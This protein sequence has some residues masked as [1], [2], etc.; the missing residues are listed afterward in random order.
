MHWR[1]WDWLTTPKSLGGMGF[2]DMALFN[3]AMLGR[4]G[5]RILSSPDS[6]CARV[7]KGRYFPQGDFWHAEVPRSASYTWRHI[8]FGR[9]LFQRGIQWGIGDG[10]KVRITGDHWIPSTPPNLLQTLF[11]IPLNATVRCL[12]D[13]D[14]GSWNEESV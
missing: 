8:L 9:E 11:P 7:L 14:L 13:D 4:Q 2:H 10:S 6:L 1:S 3:Q 5:K 12:L